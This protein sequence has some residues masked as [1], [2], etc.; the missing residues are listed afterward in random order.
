MAKRKIDPN[1]QNINIFGVLAKACEKHQPSK[2]ESSEMT[3]P[4]FEE[5]NEVPDENQ[6]FK[7]SKFE[8][9]FKSINKDIPQ[10]NPQIDRGRLTEV[11]L[12]SP[13]KLLFKNTLIKSVVPDSASRNKLLYKKKN[14]EYS[15][16]N[17]VFPTNNLNSPFMNSKNKEKVLALKQNDTLSMYNSNPMNPI[18]KERLLKEY[19]KAKEN[20]ISPNI[21]F[22]G[23][24]STI[25]K[26]QPIKKKEISKIKESKNEN[27]EEEKCNFNE[28]EM[29]ENS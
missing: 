2:K 17:Y 26:D 20:P 15:P 11:N 18:S 14:R 19:M 24:N 23:I 1:S 21:M 27:D 25:Q 29:N 9:D 8:F 10:K 12:P 22:Y 7:E 5:V 4:E 28:D 16:P 3:N 6:I 13:D